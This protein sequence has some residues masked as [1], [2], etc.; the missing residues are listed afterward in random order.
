MGL[1]GCW[2]LGIG[3]RRGIRHELCGAVSFVTETCPH[4]NMFK[5][6]V[7]FGSDVSFDEV[8]FFFRT[9]NFGC[10]RN[11]SRVILGTVENTRGYELIDSL[12]FLSIQIVIFIR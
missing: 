2:P 12:Y 4:V 8:G 5:I 6:S 9:S 7:R 3:A 1:T 10:T 11:Y